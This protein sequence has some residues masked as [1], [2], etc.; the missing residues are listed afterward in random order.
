MTTAPH[1][2]GA[3]DTALRKDIRMVTTI[4][5][6]TL[7]RAEGQQLLDLVEQV[8]AHSKGDRLED[9]PEFDLETTIRL[10]RAFTAYFHLANVT[11]QVHRGR[12]LLRR[13]EAEG[14]WLEQA[15]AR[16]EKAGVD[17][18]DIA[19]GLRQVGGASGVHRPS[20]RGRP[21]VDDRQA[22]SGGGPAGGAG[23][24]VDAPDGWRRPSSCSGTP[25]RSASNRPSPSTRRATASTTSRGCRPGPCPTCSTSCGTSWPTAGSSCPRTAVPCRSAAGWA[26]TVTATPT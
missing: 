7:V 6:E 20:D 5:G 22:A 17:V 24:A 19:E 14:G 26:V 8:R 4:L 18:D 3:P 1:S 15:I 16:I 23:R 12:A 2:F 10:V 11:E 21:P 13:S 9:L 25:T